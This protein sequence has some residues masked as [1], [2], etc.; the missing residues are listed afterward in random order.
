MKLWNWIRSMR[1]AAR[2]LKERDEA[3][4]TMTSYYDRIQVLERERDEAR[5]RA[6]MYLNRAETLAGVRTLVEADAARYQWLRNWSNGRERRK[7][8]MQAASTEGFD[9][10]IDAEIKAELA[11]S[12]NNG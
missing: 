9:T 3:V 8:F 12:A 5:G 4:R 10:A 2:I 11:R 7:V 1:D 6:A